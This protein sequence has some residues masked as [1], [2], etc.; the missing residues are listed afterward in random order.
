[1]GKACGLD[2]Q[3]VDHGVLRSV[4]SPDGWLVGTRVLLVV[5]GL[6]G[7]EVG[8]G[9]V[10]ELRVQQRR[11]YGVVRGV[12]GGGVVVMNVVVER[13]LTVSL[14]VVS[15]DGWLCRGT[16][17]EGARAA[18]EVGARVPRQARWGHAVVVQL[19]TLRHHQVLVQVSHR[20]R[21]CH[22]YNTST[23]RLKAV[24]IC[25]RRP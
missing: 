6:T 5:T 23:S 17:T 24:A 25:C 7:Q 21:L 3:L 10:V 2:G 13:G 16:V 12:G 20:R 9:V 11:Q 22:H 4:G 8:P 15:A 1:M 19:L 14:E 18:E